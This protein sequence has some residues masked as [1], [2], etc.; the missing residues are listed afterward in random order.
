MPC[1]WRRLRR[2]PAVSTR[3]NVLSPRW[4]TVSIESRVVPGISETITRSWPSSLFTRL[5]LP[6]FGRPRIATRLVSSLA[7]VGGGRD[8]DVVAALD[9]DAGGVD[10]QEPL[11]APLADGLLGVARGPR[12]LVDDG[13]PRAGQPVHERRLADVR[14]ADD[15]DGS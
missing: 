2:R 15:R 6:T 14:E 13:R 1:R 3:T 5:D 10:E 4:S 11:V 8:G 7:R 12:R 9:V